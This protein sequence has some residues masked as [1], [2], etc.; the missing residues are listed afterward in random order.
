MCSA[1]ILVFSARL[2]VN[3]RIGGLRNSCRFKVMEVPILASGGKLGEVNA[4]GDV[5][6]H[7]AVHVNGLV[8]SD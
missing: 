6:W 2:H 7:I 3:L 5:V 1:T 4:A 8:I